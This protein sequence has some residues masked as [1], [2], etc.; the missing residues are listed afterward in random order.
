MHMSDALISP[1][2][3]G[4]MTAAS[5]GL[6]AYSVAKSKKDI[7]KSILMGAVGALSF[8]AQ[9]INFAIPQTGSSGH[10]VG[11]ILHRLLGALSW[12]YYM[13]IIL[14]VQTLFCRQA[15]WQSDAIYLI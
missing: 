4:V 5:A 15:Y 3:G 7:D 14:L 10:I 2:V 9:M 1:A 8:A 12:V 13:S 6:L 11:G